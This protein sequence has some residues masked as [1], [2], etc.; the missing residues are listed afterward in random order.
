MPPKA[1]VSAQ[2]GG[3]RFLQDT[4]G[5]RFASGRMCADHDATLYYQTF[6]QLLLISGENMAVSLT[7]HVASA[8]KAASF[9]KYPDAKMFRGLMGLDDGDEYGFASD[10]EV[11]WRHIGDVDPRGEQA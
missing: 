8:S 5:L 9:L 6:D 1:A 11:N 7:N 2:Q 4:N 10:I 3:R